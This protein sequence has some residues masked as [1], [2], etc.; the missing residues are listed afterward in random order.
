MNTSMRYASQG[1]TYD[2][3]N[4]TK[5]EE[6]RTENRHDPSNVALG[7]PAVPEQ[8][9]RHT[10]SPNDHGRKAVFW[11]HASRTLGLLRHDGICR[12]PESSQA[13]EHADADAEVCQTN[14]A[15]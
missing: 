2:G 10:S 8:S 3:S 14:S 15:L 5:S 12:D 9:N 13:D 6:R 1:A 4:Q 11:L 7:R